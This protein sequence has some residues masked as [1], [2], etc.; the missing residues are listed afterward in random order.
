MEAEAAEHA[1]AQ[2]EANAEK[3]RLEAE[4]AERAQ[5]EA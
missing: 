2:A 5:R 3:E 4:D 1:L